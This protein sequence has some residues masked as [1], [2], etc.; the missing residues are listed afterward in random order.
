M[1]SKPEEAEFWRQISQFYE[2][3]TFTDV[4]LRCGTSAAGSESDV[5]CHSLI[6]SS[7]STFLG[8]ILAS[9]Y[10]S[11]E[12]ENLLILLPDFPPGD[13]RFALDQI[14]QLCISGDGSWKGILD[15]IDTGLVSTLLLEATQQKIKK[16]S[17]AVE[18]N[19]APIQ[20]M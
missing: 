18:E 15:T 7:L 2:D 14:Y 20:G 12:E 4:T 16:E 19:P 11:S 1:D 9:E 10:S 8:T 13:V 6:L 5:Y 17:F 3:G